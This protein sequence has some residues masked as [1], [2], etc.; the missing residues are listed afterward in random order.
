MNDVTAIAR[1][2]RILWAAICAG[3]AVVLVV[4]GGL[5]ATA[6]TILPEYAQAAF[7][8]TALVSLGGLG[9]ALYLI[10]TMEG[11]LIQAGSDA[12]A[13][14]IIRSMGISALAIVDATVVVAGVAAFLTGDTLVLAF[15]VPLFLFA[16]MTWPSDG[17]VA[18]WLSMRTW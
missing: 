7:Y 11:R 3:G 5:A 14:A 12:E 13:Q 15:G 8:L 1:P 17:R 9:A 18:R 16:W 2:L 6:G 4:M 10:R